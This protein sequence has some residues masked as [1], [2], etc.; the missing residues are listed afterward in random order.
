MS[1]STSTAL[2]Q[3]SAE[4]AGGGVYTG[5][6]LQASGSSL[7][8][9]VYYSSHAE[10]NYN[11]KGNYNFTLGPYTQVIFSVSASLQTQT[12]VGYDG[13]NDEWAAAQ[14]QLYIVEPNGSFYSADFVFA[15]ASYDQIFNPSNGS[16]DYYGQNI[17]NSR[18]LGVTWANSDEIEKNGGLNAIALTY[19]LSNIQAVPEPETYAML[20][21]G[22]GLI[23]FTARRKRMV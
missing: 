4:V 18:L 14:A 10:S 16:F 21:A 12:T 1:G 7:G 6:A 17:N 11:H 2:G 5:H 15:R 13:V 20:L 19:G 3:A 9:Q 8:E 23:G 22:L